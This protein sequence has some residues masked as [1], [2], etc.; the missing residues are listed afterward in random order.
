MT[1]ENQEKEPMFSQEEL[2]RKLKEGQEEYVNRM[3]YINDMADT[4]DLDKD[5]KR[6]LL[7]ETASKEQVLEAVVKRQDEIARS[8]KNVKTG[9]PE[10]IAAVSSE[11][12]DN[13]KQKYDLI[14]VFRSLRD[15]DYNSK[16]FGYARE[17][18]KELSRGVHL[19][20]N[21]IMIPFGALIDSNDML[22]IINE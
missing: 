5:V 4:H 2:Q 9:E 18:S 16:A 8:R 14:E 13:G 20:P 3:N 6:K 7:A 22:L 1:K 21:S 15:R 17:V 11:T 12:Y 19:G 10:P